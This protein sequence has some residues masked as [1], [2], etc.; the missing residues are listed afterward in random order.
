MDAH[1]I[2]LLISEAIK[3]RP[4]VT[5][6]PMNLY[7]HKNR[8]ICG[9]RLLMP[10]DAAFIAHLSPHHLQNGID[11]KDWKKIVEEAKKEKEEQA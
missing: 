2:E 7:V 11:S 9:A 4:T 6:A 8:I 1:E 3:A 5:T 10:K